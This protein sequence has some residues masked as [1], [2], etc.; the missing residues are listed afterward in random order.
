MPTFGKRYIHMYSS[1]REAALIFVK[2]IL[3]VEEGLYCNSF[4]HELLSEDKKKNQRT[5]KKHVYLK[6]T[7]RTY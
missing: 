4:Y 2:I 3:N 5:N 6:K 1:V 7:F